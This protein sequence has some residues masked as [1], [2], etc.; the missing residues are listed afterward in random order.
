M[1]NNNSTKDKYV[2]VNINELARLIKTWG[3]SKNFI[4]P[5]SIVGRDG[6]KMLARLML[7][8]S[9]ASEAAEAVRMGDL[10]S[11]QE[12]LADI[13]IRVLHICGVLGIDIQAVVASKMVINELR[14]IHH[15][16]AINT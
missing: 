1:D 10:N 6:E 12:E 9:E 5:K 2:D 7:V 13:L 15:G 16:K 8:V 3:W 14:P 4:M 11:F